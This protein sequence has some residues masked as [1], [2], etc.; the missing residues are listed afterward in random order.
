MRWKITGVLFLA[1]F[2]SGCTSYGPVIKGHR[3]NQYFVVET[4]KGLLSSS[5]SI[6]EYYQIPSGPNAGRLAKVRTVLSADTP[7]LQRRPRKSSKPAPAKKTAE[8]PGD[9]KKK[10]TGNSDWGTWE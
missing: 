1:L 2:A 9:Q 8:K 4:V 10:K 5:S 7:T 3:E 6:V